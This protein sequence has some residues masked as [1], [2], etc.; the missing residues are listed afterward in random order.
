MKG[1]MGWSVLAA[2]VVALL[3]VG[4]TADSGPR[5]PEERVEAISKRVACPVCDGESVFDSRNNASA[6]IRTEITRQVAAGVLTDDEIITFIEQS[7]GGRVLL[8][9]KATGIDALVWVLPVFVMV[10]AVVGL[11]VTFRR[12]KREGAA[13]V[14]DD[15][16]RALVAAALADEADGP[17]DPEA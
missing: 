7:Y 15:D 5:T 13:G 6:A 11:A 14:P 10:C 2:V 1:W 9:P 8:V 4:A 17:R 3:A 16:D 12:W